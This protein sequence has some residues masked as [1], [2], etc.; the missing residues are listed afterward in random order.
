MLPFILFQSCLDAFLKTEEMKGESK[1]KCP[2]CKQYRNALKKIDIWK[3]PPLLIVHLKRFRYV[4]VWRDKITTN[5]DYPIDNFNLSKYLINRENKNPNYK[6]YAISSHTGTL[7]GGHYTAS[8]RNPRLNR[9]F[10]F[11]DSK[12][13]EISNSNSL[14]SAS[15]YILFYSNI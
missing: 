15:S 11:D 3:L 12:V 7:D 1:W 9:W 14:R 6:L 13:E 10:R 8:C 4:D 2:D 5:V